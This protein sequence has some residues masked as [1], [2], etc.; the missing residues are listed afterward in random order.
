MNCKHCGCLLE[1]GSKFCKECGTPILE[2]V[3]PIT[4]DAIV[5]GDLEHTSSFDVFN[6]TVEQPIKPKVKE[7]VEE[8]DRRGFAFIWGCTLTLLSLCIVLAFYPY[9]IQ[10]QTVE[11][12]TL[13]PFAGDVY[14]EQKN[15][16]NE[17][18]VFL[19]RDHIYIGHDNGLYEYDMYYRNKVKV[20]DGYVE[21]IFV[22]DD[23][24]YYCD[25]FNDYYMLDRNSK[26]KTLL[27]ED[28]FYVQNLGDF[29]Y[30]Q[31]D[32]DGET[33]YEYNVSTKTVKKISDE[34]S[35][36]I[37]I[38]ENSRYAYYTNQAQELCQVSL[39]GSI[40]LVLAQDVRDYFFDG[41]MLYYVTSDALESID[42]ITKER[43]TVLY[44]KKMH[45][46]NKFN[47]YLFCDN[48]MDGPFYINDQGEEVYLDLDS[49][50][51][52]QIVGNRFIYQDVLDFTIYS[53]NIHGDQQSIVVMD[54]LRIRFKED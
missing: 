22:N 43:N 40:K 28:A 45:Y 53:S 21:Y 31:N 20:I 15:N 4:V 27:I 8:E 11:P 26:E 39:E 9:F 38:D 2:D 35:Y 24:F 42:T 36:N 18:Y 46:V 19:H 44:K 1:M 5:K 47:G 48:A 23:Y 49:V 12:E 37:T 13:L 29:I 25:A 32:K 16:H 6:K 51:N 34:V 33:I 17:G 3:V 7:V 41:K 10:S 14:S 52:G 50:S 30:Y 54:C